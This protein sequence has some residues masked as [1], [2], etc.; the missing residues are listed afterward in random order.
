MAKGEG[1]MSLEF[2]AAET[3]QRFGYQA[4][5]PAAGLAPVRENL[6]TGMRAV[7]E[8]LDGGLLAG[9]T[10]CISGEP[11]SGA[12]NLLYRAVA[13]AQAQGIPVLYLDMARLLDAPKAAS[14]GVDIGRL[15]LPSGSSLK[16]A[17]HL[18]HSLAQQG[19]PGLVVFDHPAPLPLAQLRA[20]LRIAPLTLLALSSGSLP[21]MQ[22]SLECQRQDWRMEWGSAVGFISEVRL[23]AHPFLPYRQV[24]A[25]FDIPRGEACATRR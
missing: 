16:Q 25:S 22:V 24:R 13:S 1:E 3:C 23:T 20:S 6:P 11:T 21:G 17:L 14:A 10:H 15:L 4:D 7:D 8:L 19:R 18:I 5:S 2:Y 12:A 9:G